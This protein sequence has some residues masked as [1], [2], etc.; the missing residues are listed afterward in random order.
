MTNKTQSNAGVGTL[1]RVSPKDSATQQQ[2]ELLC[3]EN[4]EFTSRVFH[5]MRSSEV[6]NVSL[7]SI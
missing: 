2:E 4:H 1:T 6:I 3:H 7:D 5:A